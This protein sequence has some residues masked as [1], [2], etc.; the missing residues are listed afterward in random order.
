MER[1]KSR[2]HNNMV[3]VITGIRRCGKSYLLFN[4]YHDFLLKDG[5]D[6]SH[7]IEIDLDAYEN[8]MLK[9]PDALYEHI[10]GRITEDGMYYIFLDEIQLVDDFESILNSLLRRRNVDIYVTG[11]NA[12]LLSKD[13]IT[14]FR[15]RG[16]TK[17]G[18]TLYAFR[19]SCLH[20]TAPCKEVFTNI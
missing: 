9:L 8:R 6:A 10:N 13:V 16:G 7:L 14:E 11:S 17:S 12:K 18:F 15:G 5:V 4:L 2:R 3:K 20:I 1:L 19:N